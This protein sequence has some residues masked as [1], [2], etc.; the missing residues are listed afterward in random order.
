MPSQPTFLRPCSERCFRSLPHLSPLRQ[1]FS[2]FP[3]PSS[4]HTN[5]LQSYNFFSTPPHPT[6]KT[7]PIHPTRPLI[8]TYPQSQSHSSALSL[9]ITLPACLLPSPRHSAKRFCRFVLPPPSF[10]LPP[11][12]PTF[13]SSLSYTRTRT[14]NY[15]SSPKPQSPPKSLP[16]G[17][18]PPNIPKHPPFYPYNP[19]QSPQMPL[20][21]KKS[22]KK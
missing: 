14:Y 4:S 15:I 17:Q 21:H 18:T 11:F 10:L 19:S 22:H 3:S 8:P 16:K 9:R 12:T 20:F 5:P 6:P 13:S 7:S 1:A 2:R